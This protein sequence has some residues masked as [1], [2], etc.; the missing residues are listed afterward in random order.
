MGEFDT[1][2]GPVLLGILCLVT[3]EYLKYWNH[4]FKDPWWIRTIV[5]A[6]FLVDT[7]HTGIGIYELW[8]LC[9]SNFSNPSIILVVDFS[10]PF[11]A[12]ATSISS[13]LAQTFLGHRVFQL[14]KSKP[15]IVVLATLSTGGFISGCIAGVKSGIIKEVSKFKSIVPLVICWLTLLSS[16]DILIT[17]VLTFV[18]IRSKTGFHR[19]D[20][21]INRLIRGAIQTGLFVSIFALGDLF[22]FIFAGKTTFYAMFA[23]PIGRIYTNTLLNTLNARIVFLQMDLESDSGGR[24]T[25]P[26]HAFPVHTTTFNYPSSSGRQ[27]YNIHVQPETPLTELVIPRQDKLNSHGR[28]SALQPEEPPLH[29]SLK[30]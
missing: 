1:S 19:T 13:V 5:I 2:V 27:T 9:V 11:T 24:W 15:L 25:A 10:I 29:D 3:N 23:Y 30:G 20:T 16:V 17:A 21:I 8:H 4:K 6:L 18:L 26:M 7:T 14:T 12:I 28:G 22:S